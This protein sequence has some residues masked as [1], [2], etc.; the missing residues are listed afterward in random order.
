MSCGQMNRDSLSFKTM[1]VSG[2]GENLMWRWIQS[3]SPT[4]Q[5]SGGSVMIWSCFCWHGHG[6]ATL[7]SNKMNSKDYLEVLR[8]HV[9]PSMDW[10]FPEGNGIFH[11]D[12]AR[13]HRA[14]IV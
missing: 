7:C 2:Y 3:A 5:V 1:D 4:V 6:S 11:D 10:Y 13:T 14:K 9:D 12:N 8:D